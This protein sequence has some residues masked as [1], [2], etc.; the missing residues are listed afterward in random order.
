MAISSEAGYQ[1]EMKMAA[2][3]GLLGLKEKHDFILS[4]NFI[5]VGNLDDLVY[6]GGGRRYFLQL[7]HSEDPNSILEKTNLIGLMKKCLISYIE[8]KK[9]TKFKEMA[10]DT[11]AII[12]TNITLDPELTWLK[13]EQRSDDIFFTTSKDGIFKFSSDK[14]E[15][16]E[17]YTLLE[18]SV[19]ESKT[20][21]SANVPGHKSLISEFLNKFI[22]AT[23]QESQR[24]LDKLIVE[25][26]RNNDEIK[27]AHDKYN[28]ILSHFNRTIEM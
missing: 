7:K 2:V 27:V 21:E 9:D 8:V 23:G 3:I 14:N 18:D 22:I 15:N 5:G 20:S 6:T 13:K 12:Y 26:I 19:K 10:N 25:E 24:K 17:L 28:S 1:F 4:S 16:I 11:N